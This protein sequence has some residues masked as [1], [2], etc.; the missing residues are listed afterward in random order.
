MFYRIL[1]GREFFPLFDLIYTYYYYHCLFFFLQVDIE[2][3]NN[4]NWYNLK[5]FGSKRSTFE[6]QDSRQDIVVRTK[7]VQIQFDTH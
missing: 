5:S 3:E 1:I 6:Y 4:S 7:L 2:L